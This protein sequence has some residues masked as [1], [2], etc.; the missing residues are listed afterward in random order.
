M[1][2]VREKQFPK[3]ETLNALCTNVRYITS[4]SEY[5]EMQKGNERKRRLDE[6]WLACAGSRDKARDLIRIYYRRVHE[7]NLFFT[8]HR[9]GWKTDRGLVH[10]VYGNPSRIYRSETEE[11][12]LYGD[13]NSLNSITFTFRRMP[14]PFSDNHYVLNRDPVYKSNWSRAVDSWRSGR[15]FNE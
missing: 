1:L 6:F 14:S 7:A 3:M 9:E 13:E 8:N 12:W 15:V 2:S 11:V 10:I 5:E 4:R